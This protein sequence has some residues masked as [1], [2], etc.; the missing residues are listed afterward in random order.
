VI[1]LVVSVGVDRFWEWAFPNSSSRWD[2]TTVIAVILAYVVIMWGRRGKGIWCKD[3][4]VASGLSQPEMKKDE[5][6]DKVIGMFN[7]GNEITNDEVE[8]ALG[9]SDATATRYLDKL[10]AEGKIV[11][12]GKEGR[13]VKYRL[14]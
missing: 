13:F 3:N 9:V 8:K 1:A 12:I 2:T 11:Q 7:S 14:K 10:E 6:L 5:N 4:G